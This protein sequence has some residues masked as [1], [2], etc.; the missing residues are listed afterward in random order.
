[1]YY[2]DVERVC[3]KADDDEP[4]GDWATSDDS[5]HDVL[6]NKKSNAMLVFILF[7]TEE[8]LVSFLCCCFAKVLSQSPRKSRLYRS[9][10]C[11]CSRSFPGTLSVLVFHMPIVMSFLPRIF[12]NAPAA[13]LTPPSWCTAEG[14]VLVIQVGDRSGM[15]C[16]LFSSHGELRAKYNLTEPIPLQVEHVAVEFV[17]ETFHPS[18]PSLRTMK[19]SAQ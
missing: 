15:V 3:P 1:M 10:S 11:V 7:S 9:I 4:A 13:C 5:V 16:Y 6:V 17:V 14:S 2:C 19:T 8:N 18:G 12:D